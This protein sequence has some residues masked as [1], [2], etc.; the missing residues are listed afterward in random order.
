MS[1]LAEAQE[2]A[3]RPGGTC[4]VARLVRRLSESEQA[5]LAEALAS[6][7]SARALCEALAKRGYEIGKHTI[8]RHRAGACQCR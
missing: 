7:V 3:K 5:E 8:E 4:G 1:L 2:L 6:D